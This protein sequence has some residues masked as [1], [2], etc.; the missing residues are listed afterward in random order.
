MSA[1]VTCEGVLVGLLADRLDCP[2]VADVPDQ[3]PARFVTVERLGGGRDRYLDRGTYA[4]QAWER[5]RSAA[6]ALAEQVADTLL[7]LPA[8]SGR[9]AGAGVV[10]VVNLPD[11]DSGQP[12]YQV[13]CNVTI[14]T[15]P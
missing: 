2:V 12:R 7:G 8:V 1:P 5:R 13:T 15:N 4:V 10:S 14:T 3:R 6:A 11:P 9:V